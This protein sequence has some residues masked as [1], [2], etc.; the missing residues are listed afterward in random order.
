ML[1]SKHCPL[2]AL[3]PF[4]HALS[5]ALVFHQMNMHVTHRLQLPRLVPKGTESSRKS[6]GIGC[7]IQY[8]STF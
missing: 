3:M 5:P 7:L 8:N 2:S 1:Q 6:V 4:H